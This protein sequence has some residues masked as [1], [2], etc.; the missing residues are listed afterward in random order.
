[1][2]GVK[3]QDLDGTDPY[4]TESVSLTALLQKSKKKISSRLRIAFFALAMELPKRHPGASGAWI[5]GFLP[6]T[7]G[8]RLCNRTT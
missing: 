4:R 3:R 5:T 8:F 2:V 1:M 6:L 7:G